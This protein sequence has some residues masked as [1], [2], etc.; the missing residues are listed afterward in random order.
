M[1]YAFHS[2][3]A[4]ESAADLPYNRDTGEYIL[5]PDI[6]EYYARVV[7]Y[8]VAHNIRNGF[9]MDPNADPLTYIDDCGDIG[10][11]GVEE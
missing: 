9:K 4:F 10:C 7:A 3:L 2:A 8:K 6:L 11:I 1:T 5:P